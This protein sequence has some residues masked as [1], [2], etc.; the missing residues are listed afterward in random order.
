[1]RN[2]AELKETILKKYGTVEFSPPIIILY[3]DDGIE[4]CTNVLSVKI[5]ITVLHHSFNV[6]MILH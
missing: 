1:M 5:A 3:T 4:H 2:A 6:D